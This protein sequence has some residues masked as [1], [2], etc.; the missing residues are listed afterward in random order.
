LHG[1]GIADR[2]L[3]LIFPP[4]SAQQSQPKPDEDTPGLFLPFTVAMPSNPPVASY[5]GT[6]AD[7]V[8]DNLSDVRI[9]RVEVIDTRWA[10]KVNNGQT[11]MRLWA[12]GITGTGLSEYGMYL[13]GVVD[14]F[15]EDVHI[16]R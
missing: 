9:E 12:K 3:V 4:T 15:F 1:A 10:L 6:V 8:L 5:A 16:D 2:P 13:G 7:L 11:V 14:A